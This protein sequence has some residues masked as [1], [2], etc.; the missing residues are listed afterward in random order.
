[1]IP[2]RI[3]SC[4]FSAVCTLIVWLGGAHLA[5]AEPP[6][7][8]ERAQHRKQIEE[9]SEIERDHLKNNFARFKDLPPEQQQKL[10][11]LNRELKE[12]E[13]NRGRLRQV[14][15]TYFDWWSDLSPGQRFDLHRETDPV[16]REMMVH[17]LLV[18][19]QERGDPGS[20]RSR[21]KQRPLNAADVDAVLNEL[22]LAL[23]EKKLRQPSEFD[24]L[25]GRQGF[26][27]HVAI[28]RLAFP[29]RWSQD[30]R[31]RGEPLW[32]SPEPA[33]VDRLGERISDPADK[34]WLFAAQFPERAM[35]LGILVAGGIRQEYE[36]A[37]PDQQ[38]LEEF[39]VQLPASQQDEIMRLSPDRARDKQIEMYRA[40]HP[41]LAV[42]EFPW[43]ELGQMQFGSWGGRS[44]G[45]RGGEPSAPA[46]RGGPP[47]GRRGPLLGPPDGEKRPRPLRDRLLR[48]KPAA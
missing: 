41:E 27:R 24:E 33:L 3:D 14:M 23:R 22:E 43:R 32:Q 18:E 38:K 6:S 16:K 36:R 29:S 10:R 30:N 13:Q 4:C 5:W 40:A 15:H 8:E 26:A 28:L 31:T 39:F 20:R 37:L 34:D 9:M 19:R 44:R 17:R 46:G 2:T 48:E 1:M 47:D 7:A 45:M 11:V 35:R 12:D 42:P 25:K 21:W